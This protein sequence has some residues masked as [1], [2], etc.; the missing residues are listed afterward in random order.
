MT[1]C[2][3]ADRCRSPPWPLPQ[4]RADDPIPHAEVRTP[5]VRQLLSGQLRC[6][7]RGAPQVAADD[8]GHLSV[9]GARLIGVLHLPIAVVGG[10]GVEDAAACFLGQILQ[11]VQQV[12]TGHRVL[13]HVAHAAVR[14]AEVADHD[15]AHA[16]HRE[17]DQYE[18][19]TELTP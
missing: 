14:G 16:E 15:Q 6:G 17:A 18:H 3:R 19:G 13:V 8:L 12:E 5:V 10:Q 1:E 9:R 2:L 4:D 7:S 11:L